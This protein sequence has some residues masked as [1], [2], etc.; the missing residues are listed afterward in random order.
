MFEGT[1]SSQNRPDRESL[2][3]KYDEMFIEERH[4]RRDA[5]ISLCR[6]LFPKVEYV[7]GQSNTFWGG[8]WVQEWEKEKRVCTSRYFS[9]YFDLTVPETDVSQ[10]EMNRALDSAHSLDTFLATLAKYLESNRFSVFIDLLRNSL[11]KLDHKRLLNILESI[12]VFGDLVSTEGPSMFF[13]VISDHVRFR[14]WLFYDLMDRLGDGRFRQ[15]VRF[16]ID[17]PAIFTI[18]NI[19]AMCDHIVS[20]KTDPA[21]RTQHNKYPDLTVEVVK[22]MEDAA[23]GTISKAADDGRLKSVPKLP[24]VLINWKR[25]GDPERANQWV[26]V[27]FL[28]QANTALQFVSTFAQPIT[29]MGSGDK[30]PKVR[31]VIAIKALRDFVN[32]DT[33]ATLVSGARDDELT[34]D[35]MAAKTLFFKEKTMLDKGI[36]PESPMG[37]MDDD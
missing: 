13:G 35:E 30:V 36:D 34:A 16:M 19:A 33:L 22:E 5:A 20:D 4:E 17:H 26:D 23:V 10:K 1:W 2:K 6:F 12:F 25:W 11:D 9:Y 32:L 3:R 21:R 37:I 18:T 14:I 27:T 8:D 31:I 24:F 29:S 28:R 15:V 7:Y